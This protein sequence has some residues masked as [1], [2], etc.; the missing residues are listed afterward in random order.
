M[1]HDFTEYAISGSD[2]AGMP[3]VNRNHMFAYTF[4][5]PP[6]DAQRKIALV[7]DEAHKAYWELTDLAKQ[8]LQSL[9]DLRQSLLQKAFAGELT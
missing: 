7:I 5:L 9:S 8:K 1:G 3:K 4:D 2:R 6:L